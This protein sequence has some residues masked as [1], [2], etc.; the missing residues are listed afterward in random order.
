MNDPYATHIEI[1]YRIWPESELDA[2]YD[3]DLAGSTS[4]EVV[5]RTP[6]TRFDADLGHDVLTGR[7]VEHRLMMYGH[8]VNLVQS[9]IGVL[10]TGERYTGFDRE[11]RAVNAVEVAR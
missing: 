2:G 1:D 8:E 3:E 6:E 4:S 5:I 10:M 7:K 11:T 9:L